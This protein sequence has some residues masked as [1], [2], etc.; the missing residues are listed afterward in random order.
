MLRTL[1]LL[2]ACCASAPSWAAD[3]LA[4]T[5]WTLRRVD[6]IYPDGRV[7]ALYGPQPEGRLLFDGSGHYAMQIYRQQRTR[8][9]A[10]DKAHGTPDEYRAAA[11]EANA[12]T[13]SYQLTQGGAAIV[14]QIAQ[15]TYANWNGT[16]QER[17]LELT[18][19]ILRYTVAA[20]TQGAGARGEVEWQRVR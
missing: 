13:G 15:A 20:P 9:A 2:A 3:P 14:F 19:D 11:L 17:P 8:I 10:G 1:L 4:N 16:V 7:Q 6:N 12:H 5:S 18:G